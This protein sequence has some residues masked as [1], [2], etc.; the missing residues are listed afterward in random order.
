MTLTAFNKEVAKDSVV[1]TAN[2]DMPEVKAQ[3]QLRYRINTAGEVQV[4]EKMTTNK[5]AA[6]PDMYRY[7]MVLDMPAT[8]SKIAY[9]GRG[10]EE[11]YVDRHAS[12]FI[13]QYQAD[14]KNE[15]YPY[16]RPQESGNHF[17]IRFFTVFN[18]TSGKGIT[19][20]G[21]APMECGA[22]PYPIEDLDAGDT[23][24]H[25]WGQH[26]GDLLDRNLTQVHIQQRQY[27]LGCIDSW[28]TKPMEKYRIHYG[29]RE[30][31][32][33]IKAK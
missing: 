30:F 10:P 4:S 13:G 11:S 31:R 23:K 19:F 24:E 25:A 21:Y 28:M 22:I 1:L 9:Y 7:G 26:S 27:G 6:V 20:E 3:L 2:F 12:A 16:V 5:E 15:Y 18:P 14:V 29:D 32:F 33:V 17:D 8:F